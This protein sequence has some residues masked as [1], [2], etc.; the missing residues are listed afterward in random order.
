MTCQG[1][2]DRPPQGPRDVP[3]PPSHSGALGAGQ[4]FEAVGSS[5]VQSAGSAV[6]T[7]AGG[8]RWGSLGSGALEGARSSGFISSQESVTAPPGG[9]LARIRSLPPPSSGVAEPSS[10]GAGFTGDPA[11]PGS[12]VSPQPQCRS[13]VSG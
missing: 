10:L 8:G 5:A 13:A 1:P 6:G 9:T 12:W 4:A 3:M 7:R 11:V 2:Q